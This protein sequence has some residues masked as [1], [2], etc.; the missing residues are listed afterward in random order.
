MIA[1]NLPVMDLVRF[2][3]LTERSRS[4]FANNLKLP[5]KPKSSS[6]GGNYWTRSVS[7]IS[8]AFKNNDNSFIHEKIES[9][10]SVY[11]STKSETTRTMYKRNL[12]ILHNYID[13]DFRTWRPPIDLQYLDNPHIT[14]IRCTNS[15]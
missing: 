8:K 9:V 7:G 5:K 3:R 14:L 10:S 12:E 6:G 2:K 13:F 11:D 15:S 1:K 4:T